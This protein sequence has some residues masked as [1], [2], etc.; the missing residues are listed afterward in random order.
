[1]PHLLVVILDDLERLPDMLQAWQAIGV[2]GV[3][4]LESVGGYRASTWLS[5]VGL[6]ALDRLFEADEVRRRTLLVAIEEDELL[7][8]AIAE[9]ERVMGGF[10]RRDSGVL[11]ALPRRVSKRAGVEM[12]RKTA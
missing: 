8:R 10:D 12:F 11:L 9:A 4:M 1:M 5:Q 3:T 2:P 6:G 7:E